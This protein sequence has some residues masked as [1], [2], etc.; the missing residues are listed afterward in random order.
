MEGKLKY[1]YENH[2][3]KSTLKSRALDI[4]LLGNVLLHSS[5]S[6]FRSVRILSKTFSRSRLLA[7]INQQSSSDLRV[8]LCGDLAL[9]VT[10]L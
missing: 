1:C 3:V 2:N 5:K 4:Q 8:S 7:G 10:V 6:F 9:K